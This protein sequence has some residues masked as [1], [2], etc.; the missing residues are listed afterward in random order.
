MLQVPLEVSKR[1]ADYRDMFLS[2]PTATQVRQA[3]CQLHSV[4]ELRACACAV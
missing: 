4:E 2:E 3:A 1:G